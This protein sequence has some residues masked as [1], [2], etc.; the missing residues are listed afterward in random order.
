MTKKTFFEY[1][2]TFSLAVIAAFLFVLLLLGVIH[3]QVYQIQD[4][5]KA[6]DSMI[7]DSLLDVLIYKNKQ[8]EYQYPDDYRINLKLGT[9]YEVKKNYKDAEFEYKTAVSKAPFDQYRPAYKL[10]NLYIFLNR[11]DEAQ[12]LIDKIDERPDKRLIKYKG[13]IYS[14]LGDKYYS[15][16]DYDNASQRY[17]KALFYY[18][19]IKCPRIDLI[20][21]NLASSYIYLAETKL[22]QMQVDDAIEYLQSAKAIF[23]APIIKYKLALLLM[24]RDPDAAYQYLNEVFEQAPEIINYDTYNKF[25]SE[26]AEDANYEG[27]F[28]QAQLYE[29]KIKKLKDYFK[30]NIISVEDLKIVVQ[31]G[32]ITLNRWVNKYNIYFELSFKNI[33]KNTMSSLF[34]NVV[35]KDGNNIV[36]TYT[37]QVADDKSKL[38][39][40]AQSPIVGMKFSLS[41]SLQDVQPKKITAEV[42]VSKSEPSYKLFLGTFDIDQNTK[43]GVQNK[44]IK[45]FRE[46]IAKITSM[47]PA[48]LF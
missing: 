6:Q 14:A 25:L 45:K 19:I 29:F 48:F 28:T 38:N 26:L 23:D 27:D 5:Q 15:Q 12:N 11:L 24:D 2:G 9:L 41:R 3:H 42:Y 32:R 37:Q 31:D 36:E 22:D 16:G 47:L 39:A 21:G 43:S 40:G 8:M 17:E 7:N 1:L 33:S 44:Y 13:D 18:K 35:F 10:A 4:Q 34:L 20:N 46:I 30:T